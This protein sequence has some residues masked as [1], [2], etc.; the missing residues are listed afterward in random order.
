MAKKKKLQIPNDLVMSI[1]MIAL[2]ILF[3]VMQGGV[4]GIAIWVLGIA[5]IVAAVLDL[6]S[7]DIVS[8]VVKAVIGIV[9]LVAGGLFVNVA[10]Y[11]LAGVLLIYGILQVIN[12]FKSKQ[13]GLLK[14]V[15]P[16]L[17]VVIALALLFGNG[18]NWIFIIIGVIFIIDGVLGI[19]NWLKK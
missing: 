19:I 12:A 6:L 11:V 17:M 3:A 9:V 1:V 15:E 13:K 7:K 4:I 8:C 14:F 5:L 16:V 2:G 10:L 18:F